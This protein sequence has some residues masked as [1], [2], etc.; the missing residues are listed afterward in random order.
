MKNFKIFRDLKILY[1]VEYTEMYIV[2]QNMRDES[3]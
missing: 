3:T 2:N 1:F